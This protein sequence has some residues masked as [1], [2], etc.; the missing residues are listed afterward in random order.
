MKWLKY[1]SMSASRFVSL[2]LTDEAK[3]WVS[4]IGTRREVR[5]QMGMLPH[6]AK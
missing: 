4:H 3:K 2:V 5:A 6:L 1:R